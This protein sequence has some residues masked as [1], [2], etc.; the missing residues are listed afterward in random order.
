[1][2]KL[3]KLAVSLLICGLMLLSGCGT[4]S[5]SLPSELKGSN[6]DYPKNINIMTPV[7]F[8]VSSAEIR[9]QWID[10][11]SERYRVQ[12][13]ITTDDFSDPAN[14]DYS[15]TATRKIQNILNGDTSYKGL[16]LIGD[17]GSDQ[18]D[19][20]TGLVNDSFLPLED[21]LA[22]NPVWNALPD[23]F[24]SLF[25]VDGHIYAI[26]TYVD[27]RM[28][29]RMIRNDAMETTGITV[30][31]L[32]SFR[33]FAIAYTEETGYPAIGNA[34]AVELGDILNAFGLYPGNNIYNPFAYDPKED[35]YVDFMTKGAA[36]EAFEYLRELYQVGALSTLYY[37]DKSAEVLASSYLGGYN[38][39]FPVIWTLNPEY[40]KPA[41]TDRKGYA[42]TKDT[43]QPKET[44][45]FLVNM[46]FGSEQNYLECWLGSSDNYILNS[47]GTITIKLVKNSEGRYTYD[48]P[49][50]VGS[51]PDIFPYSNA[52]IYYSKNGIIDM[53]P[54][55]NNGTINAFVKQKKDLFKSGTV[56]EI[57]LKYL[58]LKSQTYNASKNDVDLLFSQYFEMAITSSDQTV[59]QILDEYN[60]K[61]LNMGG[62][63]MLDEMNAAIGKKTAYYYG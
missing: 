29:T 14:V 63:Q 59:Q 30:T 11:M 16:F 54:G 47:D 46:L 39:K 23:Y 21:Y 9:Q 44:V 40:P 7:F 34:D 57:P 58:N 4:P 22:D 6:T 31:D 60:Q 48:K 12:I 61:M 45:N 27:Q 32:D 17:D 25:E 33:D 41:A 1:M 42:M 55:T 3:F 18:S 26:P 5:T 35:C 10:E 28:K 24:K 13:N 51:L 53:E 8:R 37:N 20:N 2:K 38:D 56:V 49:S 43:P 36:V 19:F 50:L 15:A 52:D 62:N